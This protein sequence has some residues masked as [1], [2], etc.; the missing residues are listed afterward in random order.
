MFTRSPGN[1][2]R[3][4]VAALALATMTFISVGATTTSADA[5]VPAAASAM[6]GS[7]TSVSGFSGNNPL[8]FFVSSN[9][10]QLQEIDA[11]SVPLTCAP[12][13]GVYQNF[14][15]E[16]VALTA[17]GVFSARATQA[18]AVSGTGA[19]GSLSYVFHGHVNNS[20]S[21]AGDLTETLSFTADSTHFSCSSN[22]ISWTATRDA[23]PPQT[24]AL[25]P[26]GSYTSTVGPSS[27]NP[28]TFFVSSNRKA[29]GHIVENSVPLS[30]TPQNGI[31]QNLDI[32]AIPLGSNG[33]FTEKGTQHPTLYGAIGT[34][35][36]TFQGHFHGLAPT[37][38]VARAAGVF[39]E[40]VTFKYNGVPFW[41]TNTVYWLATL[42]GK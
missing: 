11:A 15:A 22:D 27:N 19:R 25:P 23:Q 1:R 36:Y 6:T 29:L 7:Y 20:G 9:R 41:C 16:V 3:A 5:Q 2:P 10:R 24:S 31:Y 33:S 37:S 26:A 18:I 13:G 12:Q 8:T 40:T 30:C 28:L 32:N 17:N 4:A 35:T 42:G 38:K 34:L 14:V 39:T 21:A